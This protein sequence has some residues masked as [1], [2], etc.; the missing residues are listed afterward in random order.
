MFMGVVGH[1][2][3]NGGRGDLGNAPDR[4]AKLIAA[5]KSYPNHADGSAYDEALLEV[6]A[7]VERSGSL[8]RYRGSDAVEAALT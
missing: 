6:Q 8:G 5:Y 3:A 4:V 2:M 7:A 1:L